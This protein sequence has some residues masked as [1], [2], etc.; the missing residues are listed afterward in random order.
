RALRAWKDLLR[1]LLRPPPLGGRGVL[2]CGLILLLSLSLSLSLDLVTL[3][4]TLARSGCRRR[5]DLLGL[6]QLVEVGA[7]ALQTKVDPARLRTVEEALQ[8]PRNNRVDVHELSARL[9][10]DVLHPERTP[11]DRELNLPSVVRE[12]PALPRQHQHAEV[13]LPLDPR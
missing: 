12:W 1:A 9:V 3:V 2:L 13:D 4:V 6:L 7:L 5:S 11:T 8:K 10:V